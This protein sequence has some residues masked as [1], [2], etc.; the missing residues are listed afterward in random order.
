MI[1][2]P[3]AVEKV[4]RSFLEVGV[5]VIETCT[6]RSNRLT[7]GEYGLG[8]K[9]FE[10]NSS[11]ARLARKVADEF[12]QPGHPRLV[13]GSIGPSGKLPSIDDPQLSNI[14][15]D[16]LSDLFKEQ[17]IGLIRGGVDL[18]IIETSQD[19]LEVKATIHG[20][21]RAFEETGIYLPIQ[22]QVT[23]DTTARML[24]GTD[25]YAVETILDGL[26]VDVIGLNCSTG[27]DLMREP[28]KALGELSPL[29]ISCI[30]NAG[31]P[32][33]VDGQA[34]YPLQP[35]PFAEALSEF[36]EKY[37]VN[38]VGG[39][40]GT[41]PEH[42]R[43][44]VQK[45]ANIPIVMRPLESEASLAS[46]VNAVQTQ[47]EPPPFLI[48]ERLNSQGSAKFKK[49]LLEE[50][51]DGIL[52]IARSQIANG[53]HGL[54][55]CVALTERADEKETMRKVIKKVSE[56]VKTPFIIDSTELDVMETALK[57]APGKCLINSTNLEAGRTK[58][59][60]VFGLAKKFNAS[61][62][63]LTI[64]ESGMAKTADRKLEIAKKIFDIAVNEFGLKPGDLIIDDLTFTLGTGQDE[65]KESA[66][67]TLKGIKLIKSELTGRI[68]LIGCQ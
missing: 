17:A 41:T 4:H 48:G 43:L 10:I 9:V 11:A 36:A 7:L 26:P 65:F 19:I 3:A 18:I 30:P 15:F 6:F 39:C 68:D 21:Q 57:T 20:I 64:D 63:A 29:P 51:Y 56:A 16:E 59:E 38:V 58:A 13:A 5:D 31:L 1:S 67:E 32:L 62:L 23:L 46:A 12:S 24:L 14:S 66:K 47:Q 54:D 61:V 35:E 22:A 42:L 52:T 50:D 8:D 34:V 40:C 60:K 53:A 44:L 28:I 55:I 2:Y 27:P 49:L 45:V 33:N 37:H 25:I